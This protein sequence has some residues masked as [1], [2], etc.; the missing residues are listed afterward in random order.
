MPS[1]NEVH[2]TGFG[3]SSDAARAH[4]VVLHAEDRQGR[5]TSGRWVDCMWC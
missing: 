5:F 2:L 3:T 1:P 4:I